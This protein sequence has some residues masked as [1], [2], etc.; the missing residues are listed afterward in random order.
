MKNYTRLS[1][2]Q[3]ISKRRHLRKYQSQ[4]ERY[5]QLIDYSYDRNIIDN[6]ESKEIRRYLNNQSELIQIILIDAGL[7]PNVIHTPAP[8]IGGLAQRI[9]LVDNLF[10]LQNYDIESQA[11]IDFIDQAYGVYERDFFKSIIRTINPLYWGGRVLEMIASSPFYLL[12]QIG[13]NQYR[14]ETSLFGR[15]IKLIIKIVSTISLFWGML[16]KLKILPETFDLFNW[17]KALRI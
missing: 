12:G 15:I 7:S 10:N 17:L 6:P 14:L 9:N 5:F 16:S 13:F 2:W 1:F 8:A 11:L 3:N 4:V